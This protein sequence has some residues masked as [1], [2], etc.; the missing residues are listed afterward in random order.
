MCRRGLLF[1]SV[2]VASCGNLPASI[3]YENALPNIFLNQAAGSFRS[4]IAFTE[5]DP[6]DNFDG[7][8]VT[9]STSQGNTA[10]V[11]S[12]TTWSVASILDSPLGNEFDSLSLYFRPLGGTWTILETGTPDTVFDANNPNQVDNSN[13]DITS[14]EVPYTSTVAA[15]ESTDPSE[16]GTYYPLWQNTFTNLNLVLT[17]GVVYQF[18]V[19]GTSAD[20]DPDTLFGYWFNSYSNAYLSG[21]IENNASGTYLRCDA[22][23]LSAP[24]F[25]EDPLTDQTWDKGANMNIEIDGTITNTPEPST[26]LM[27]GTAVLGLVSLLR[28]RIR[29]RKRSA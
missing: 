6:I 15:Y 18:A 3:I 4:N 22:T 14:T 5:S 26:F 7:T 29:S 28:N 20:P 10:F 27:S 9:F 21:A 25:V 1:I 12:L 16:A 24:C 23:N 19:W 2:L 17:T 8:D 11:S 13:P